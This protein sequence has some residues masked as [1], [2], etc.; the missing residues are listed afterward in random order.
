MHVAYAGDLAETGDDAIEMAN[1]IDFEDY[2]DGR[3]AIDAS[4]LDVADVGV[5][6]ADDGR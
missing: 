1:V 3:E 2:I 5:V 4:C 6:V